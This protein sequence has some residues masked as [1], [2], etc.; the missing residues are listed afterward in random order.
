M[1]KWTADELKIIVDETIK[2]PN[3]HGIGILKFIAS[4]NSKG[5]VC[6]YNLAY[7]NFNICK[8]DDGIV[9]GYEQNHECHRRHYMGK[10]EDVDFTTYEAIAE[11]FESEWREIHEERQK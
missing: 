2:L 6:E 8:I 1:D 9:L 5:E 10:I 7:I 11:R 3:K 4:A